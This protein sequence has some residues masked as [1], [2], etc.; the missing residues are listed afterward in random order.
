[1]TMKCEDCGE[2]FS[3]NM[4]LPVRNGYVESQTYRAHK[5]EGRNGHPDDGMEGRHMMPR[6]KMM[7]G[8]CRMPKP[9]KNRQ[10][11]ERDDHEYPF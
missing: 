2:N 9:D 6:N 10:D 3:M 5:P 4:L 7:C 11:T 1:M 8:A